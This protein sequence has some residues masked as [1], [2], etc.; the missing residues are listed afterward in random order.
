MALSAALHIHTASRNG[1]TILKNCYYK[2]PFKIAD[3]TEDKKQQRLEL[4]LM[5][6]SP[7]MLDG[8]K[9]D[10]LIEVGAHCSLQLTTQSYQ[11]LFNMKQ[12]ASHKMEVRLGS[13]AF[14][15]YLPH[16]AVPHENSDYRS[17]NKIYLSDDSTL[18]WAETISCGRKLNGE[19]FRFRQYHSVTEIFMNDRLVVK[20]NLLIKPS[21]IN[22]AG[23]GFMEGFTHQ[24]T[25]LYIKQNIDAKELSA[26]LNDHHSSQQNITYGITALPVSGMLVRI[27][28]YSAEQL[29]D[30]VKQLSII[31][32][33]FTIK[34]AAYAG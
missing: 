24:A 14:F 25:L 28:G 23:I 5:S 22:V 2:P 31:M 29:F 18:L 9:Y 33:S 6:S 1:K 13:G 7:G 21:E 30:N 20:E 19:L 34:R 17:N 3:V 27:M 11:R 32:G 12:G 26:V 8:D 16:P 4:M 10:V 15:N